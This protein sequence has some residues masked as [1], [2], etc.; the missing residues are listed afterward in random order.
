VE[1]S[2]ALSDGPFQDLEWYYAD[3]GFRSRKV[4]EKSHEPIANLA[5]TVLGHRHG[6][7]LDLGC[8]NGVL[9]SKICH[10]RHHVPWGLDHSAT[11]IAH[12]R[13]LNPRFADNFACADIFGDCEV[14]AEAREFELVILM[15]GR[16]TEVSE[17]RAEALLCSIRK[18]ARNLVVYVYD[19]Y[20]QRYGSISELAQK[21]G[22]TLF[23]ELQDM[24]VAMVRLDELDF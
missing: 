22:V 8:G 3:N 4:M 7:V 16:L 1:H 14:W 18:H 24:N 9:L 19:G 2:D 21:A 11:K 20:Q 15:L 13:L 10:A 5:V 23:H 17:D 6:N 12:A